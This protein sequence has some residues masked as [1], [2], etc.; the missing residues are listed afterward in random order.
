MPNNIVNATECLTQ[1]IFY[2]L[3]TYENVQL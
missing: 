1:S 2:Q 3:V